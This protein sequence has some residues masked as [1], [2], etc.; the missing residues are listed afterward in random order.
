VLLLLVVEWSEGCVMEEG[1][2]NEA[3]LG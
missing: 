3:L 1:V 2:V